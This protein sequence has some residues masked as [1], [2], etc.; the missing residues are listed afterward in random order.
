MIETNFESC[1]RAYTSWTLVR[2][3]TPICSTNSSWYPPFC[4]ICLDS[5]NE[6]VKRPDISLDLIL[7][8]CVL[9]TASRADP[10]ADDFHDTYWRRH[11]RDSVIERA[12]FQVRHSR[13]WRRIQI[14]PLGTNRAWLIKMSSD[15]RSLTRPPTSRRGPTW[16]MSQLHMLVG[17]EV[18]M[19]CSI[20]TSNP[21]TRLPDESRHPTMSFTTLPTTDVS[22]EV[23]D[24][25]RFVMIPLISRC[26]FDVTSF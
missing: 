5:N 26:Q 9:M 19:R 18:V 14:K 15:Y 1:E 17:Q 20:R 25:P 22:L 12:F 11:G 7:Q 6:Y 2:V 16:C 4:I 24:L 10:V 23:Q 8:V 13:I 21:L 3:V